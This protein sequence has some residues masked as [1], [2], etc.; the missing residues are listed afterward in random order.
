MKESLSGHDAVHATLRRLEQYATLSPFSRLFYRLIYE[1]VYTPAAKANKLEQA[2]HLLLRCECRKHQAVTRVVHN[3]RLDVLR[4]IRIGRA[5]RRIVRRLRQAIER[6]EPADRNDGIT[7]ELLLAAC[8]YQLGETEET[9]RALRRAIGMGCSHPLLYFTLGY[10]LYCFA[11]Q[12]CTLIDLQTGGI[13]AKDRT[14]FESVCREAIS[15]F[16]QGLGSGTFDAQLLWWIGAISE[17]L[18]DRVAAR[19]SFVKAAQVDPENFVARVEEKLRD[20]GR[21]VVVTRAAAERERLSRLTPITD[22][23]IAEAKE[24]LAGSDP[25]PPL[26]FETENG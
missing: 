7:R 16:R 19:R 4:I 26:S 15:A 12:H 18:G 8:C 2:F 11:L 17:I 23:E 14:A 10:N 3:G 6:M 22:A 1:R 25:F 21:T 24:L 20:L 5:A 9:N 13:A